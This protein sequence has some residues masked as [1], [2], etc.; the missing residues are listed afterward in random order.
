MAQR[1]LK[2]HI[3]Q[4]MDTSWPVKWDDVFA[5][6]RVL[7][8]K[9]ANDDILEN[10]ERAK[11]RG[12]SWLKQMQQRKKIGGGGGGGGSIDRLQ[13]IESRYKM[14]RVPKFAQ[15]GPVYD[16]YKAAM[17]ARVLMREMTVKMVEG[18]QAQA[19]EQK[20]E[21]DE[22]RVLGYDVLYAPNGDL[23]MGVRLPKK[24]GR[25]A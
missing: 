9:W 17:L 14:V 16:P 4:A 21:D 25:R 12:T 8:V 6:A 23:C 7:D 1:Q 5:Q 20:D 22:D 3:A 19:E 2:R 10:E 11:L 24:E 13:A 18:M 15:G